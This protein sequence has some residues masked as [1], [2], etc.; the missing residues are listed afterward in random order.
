MI[1]FNKNREITHEEWWEIIYKLG[2]KEKVVSAKNIVIKPNF[3]AGTYVNPKNH[4]ITDLKLLKSIIEF[5]VSVNANAKIYISESDSTG[6]GFAYLKFEHLGLPKSLGLSREAESRIQLLDLSRDRLIRVEDSRF[7]RYVNID[8]QLWLSETLVNADLKVNLSNLKTHAVTGYTGACKNLFGCLPDL[9]KYHNHPYIHKTIHDLTLALHPDLNVVDA[10]YGMEGNGPV[11]GEDKD[12]GYR[13]FS[14]NAIE[15]DIFAAASIGYERQKIVYLKLLD[16]TLGN[17]AYDNLQISMKYKR[18][19]IFLRAMNTIGL[20][21]QKFGLCI[22]ML[23]HKIH[24]CPTP[25]ILIIT[26]IRPIMLKIFDYEKLK[27]WKRKIL[28]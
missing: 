11:Q 13:I 26:L 27:R 14:D 15:A 7:K 21:I 23:G 18:P 12:S 19:D 6:Y 4:V 16:K 5:F 20:S 28:K 24:S 22:E 3:A 17:I 8:Q 9:E 2:L 10:F 1:Y 25:I